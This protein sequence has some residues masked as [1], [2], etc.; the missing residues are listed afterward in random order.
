MR[1]RKDKSL[2]LRESEL[3]RTASFW[4]FSQ[5]LRAGFT[6]TGVLSEERYAPPC[7]FILRGKQEHGQKTLPKERET[8]HQPELPQPE[9]R[10]KHPDISRSENM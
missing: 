5:F 3:S 1:C 8:A 10:I 6:E 4:L 2:S 7:A 9:V